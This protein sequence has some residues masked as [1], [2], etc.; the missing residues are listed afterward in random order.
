MLICNN[1]I[2]KEMCQCTNQCFKLFSLKIGQL[3]RKAKRMPVFCV[4]HLSFFIL[5]LADHDQ[6]KKH[7]NEL[8]YI[9]LDNYSLLLNWLS[10]C[11]TS[12]GTY[13]HAF[14]GLKINHQSFK[15]LAL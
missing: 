6:L 11:C 2:P 5:N 15:I 9:T 14:N 3:S 8:K 13:L 7:F 12:V 4:S 1:E 10:H